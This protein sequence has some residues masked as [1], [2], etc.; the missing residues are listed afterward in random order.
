MKD[1][2]LFATDL[3]LY[4]G[5][6]N[7]Y[8]DNFA[9][10]LVKRGRL[11]YVAST[12]G[13]SGSAFYEV[14]KFD[15]PM[16]RPVSVLD[17][18]MP[19]SKLR[20]LQ[21][22]GRVYGKAVTGFAGLEID[23]AKDMVIFT[24]YYTWQFDVLIRAA[25]RLKI[26]YGIVF[27][28]LDLLWIKEKR[29][30]HFQANFSGAELVIYNSRATQALQRQLFGTKH[31]NE[32]IVYPGIDVKKIEG[33][34]ERSMAGRTTADGSVAARSMAEWS[35]ADRSEKQIV[36][37]TVSRLVKRKGIDIAIRIVHALAGLDHQVRYYIGGV[38][39]E[40]ERLGALIKELNAGEY[41]FLL[42][43]LEEAEKYRLLADSDVFILPTHSN[44]N[45]DFEGFGISF[46]EASLFGN[47]VIGGNHGGVTEAVV[48][49]ETGFLFDFDEEASIGKAVAVIAACIDDPGRMEKIKKAGIGYVKREF[50]WNAIVGKFIG[51]E[52]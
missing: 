9:V 1:Y 33:M 7:D 35:V 25:R 29:F 27:H 11:R 22:V 52:A 21:Y 3:F 34:A 20:T 38:G 13:K 28:G 41:I 43:S 44:K 31:P 6:V 4:N 15:L 39:E 50:D 26:P 23:K 18:L 48:D 32:Q 17:K 10:Q 30:R 45:T 14:K 40:G 2:I 5:G 36:F 8:T 37:S 12:Y 49:G 24:D 19:L 47:V 16:S 51:E 42:G 46:I